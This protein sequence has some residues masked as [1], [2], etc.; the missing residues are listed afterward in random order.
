MTNIRERLTDLGLSSNWVILM[1]DKRGLTT[2]KSEFSE[3]VAGHRTGP[4][5]NNI[6][7]M[8]NEII[9][10]YEHSDFYRQYG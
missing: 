6:I 9:D 10:A 4:K 2:S 8:A 5:V 3:A 1:M 7:A